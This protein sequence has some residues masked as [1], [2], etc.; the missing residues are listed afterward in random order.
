MMGEVSLE[1]S[2]KNMMIQYMINS[3]NGMNTTESTNTNIFK[4]FILLFFGHF[5]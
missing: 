5:V 3:K 4:R 2:P 1:T